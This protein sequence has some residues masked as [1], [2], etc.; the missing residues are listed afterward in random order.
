MNKKMFF[1][2]IMSLA[3]A[4]QYQIGA[5]EPETIYLGSIELSLGMKQDYV[6]ARLSENFSLQELKS[7]TGSTSST[8]MVTTKGAP[9]FT[10]L[11][12]VS[13]SGEKLNSVVRDWSPEDQQKG[14]ELGR[15]L[16]R[17]ISQFVKEGKAVCFL[18]AGESGSPQ[19]ERKDASLICGKKTIRLGL[20]EG[21]E[22]RFT[23]LDEKLGD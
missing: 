8:W 13:F 15:S 17:L 18:T 10:V 19:Y 22:G 7:G 14:F 21:K 16:Y 5:S 2:L 12:M 3:L 23:N 9:P 4:P 20:L 6:M 1:F 11:G